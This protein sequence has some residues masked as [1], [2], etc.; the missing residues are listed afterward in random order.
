MKRQ[1]GARDRRA[2]FWRDGADEDPTQ[3]RSKNLPATHQARLQSDV[4]FAVDQL[5]VA[6]GHHGFFDC[7][8]F[9]MPVQA[10]GFIA[11]RRDH[12][13][14][15]GDD[16]PNRR[17]PV[18]RRDLGA[19]QS[20]FHGL[21][22]KRNATIAQP[23]LCLLPRACDRQKTENRVIRVKPALLTPLPPIGLIRRQTARTALRANAEQIAS[24]VWRSIGWRGARIADRFAIARPTAF[25]RSFP[26]RA[27]SL[28]FR[29]E[30]PFCR[31]RQSSNALKIIRP[32]PQKQTSALPKQ[33]GLVLFPPPQSPAPLNR[34]QATRPH[35]FFQGQKQPQIFGSQR[36]AELLGDREYGKRPKTTQIGQRADADGSQN[37]SQGVAQPRQGFIFIHSK[38][39]SLP[40]NWAHLLLSTLASA[41]PFPG[42]KRFRQNCPPLCPRKEPNRR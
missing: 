1:G 2:R 14:F 16:G 38:P 26:S 18:L 7:D 35:S 31:G 21:L 23:G 25:P 22:M 19:A 32:Q 15:L 6:Q 29:A 12:S 3:A 9:R 42:N 4:Q 33:G 34:A 36:R 24:P 27:R 11:R 30:R 39:Q 20:L 28:I 41:S 10:A 13:A 17:R 37:R 40:T 8:H 5:V